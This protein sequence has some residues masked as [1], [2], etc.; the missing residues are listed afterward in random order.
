MKT[1]PDEFQFIILENTGLHA[2]QINDI[3]LQSASCE[4]LLGII[5]I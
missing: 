3:T 1:N 4:T 2:L 5:L